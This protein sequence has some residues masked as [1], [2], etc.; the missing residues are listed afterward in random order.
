MA[1]EPARQVTIRNLRWYHNKRVELILALGS[2]CVD[3]GRDNRLEFDHIDGR[4]WDVAR[5]S[6][7]QRIRIYEREI[8]KGLIAL[9]CKKCNIKKG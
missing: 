9:R 4:D 7:W 1:K 3:C 8:K 6:P 2:K 5:K